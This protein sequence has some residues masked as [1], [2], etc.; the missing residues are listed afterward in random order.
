MRP[1]MA[2]AQLP[3]FIGSAFPHKLS[4]WALPI[5]TA[6]LIITDVFWVDMNSMRM[7]MI[8]AGFIALAGIPH[9]TLDVE[10]AAGR[11]GLSSTAG[12]AKIIGAYLACAM[13]MLFFWTIC[14]K[15]R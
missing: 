7:T 14:L 11:F 1:H 13:A 15:A 6:M 4:L 3:R 5:I 10:I 8:A 2:A 9:G 12:K